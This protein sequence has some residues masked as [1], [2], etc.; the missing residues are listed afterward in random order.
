MRNLSLVST[1]LFL[2][3]AATA[4]GQVVSEKAHKI[5]YQLTDGEPETHKKFLRQIHNVLEL[6]P[7][8]QIEVV[9]HGM[10]IDLL[11]N[12]NNPF[13]KDLQELSDRGVVFLVCENTMKQ[14]QLSKDKFLKMAGFVPSAI[15]ELVTKQE[16]GWIYIKA[17]G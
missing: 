14:R 12:Q 2:V 6:A 1:L 9:T 15:L 3:L 8:A 13:E 11:Q 10:G 16:E 7:N 4:Q 5:L 17:G